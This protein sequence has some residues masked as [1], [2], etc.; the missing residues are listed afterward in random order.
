MY[1]P[2]NEIYEFGEFRLDVSERI[3]SRNGE[4][5]AVAEKAFETL[6]VLV[7]N[8]NHLL[9]KAE[10]MKAIWPDTIVEENNLDKNISYLRRILGEMPEHP[11]FIETV[12]G[13]GYRFAVNKVSGESQ[14]HPAGNPPAAR[15][16]AIAAEGDQPMS[17]GLPGIQSN[18]VSLAGWHQSE[19]SDRPVAAPNIPS[20]DEVVTRDTADAASILKPA[21]RR[22]IAILAG[23]AVI[24][25]AIG[26]GVY[27]RSR[28]PAPDVTSIAV[29][30]FFNTSH[31]PA[32][33]YLS[34]GITESIINDLSQTTGLKVMSR[35]SAFQFKDDQ[36]D[37]RVIAS[38]LGVQRIITGDITQVADKLVINVRLLDTV[39][40]SQIW[41]SQYVRTAADVVALQNEIASDISRKLGPQLPGDK[42]RFPIRYTDNPEAY[43]LFLKGRYHLE[44]HTPQ[45]ARKALRYFQDAAALDSNFAAAYAYIAYLYIGFA[46]AKDFPSRESN[47]KARENVM[48]SL[49]LDDQLSTA[50]EVYGFILLN[51]D[52]NFVAAEHEFLRALE[53]D[54]NDASARETYGLMLGSLGK[55][56]ESLTELQKAIDINPLSASISS[57]YGGAL[58]TARRYDEA[59]EHLKRSLEL[60]PDFIQTHYNLAIVYQM[61]G[62]YADSVEERARIAEAIRDPA[63]AGFIRES[64]AR[65]G[66]AGFLRDMTEDPHAPY[67]P[68]YIKATL[69]AA[70]GDKDKTLAILQKRYEEGGAGLTTLRVDPR[71]DPVRDDPRFAELLKR[72]NLE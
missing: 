70:R 63:A 67:V 20:G 62:N 23:V 25:S 28:D 1:Q 66:W 32:A 41:G 44:K 35:N 3:L 27:L 7:K 52:F 34:D 21:F 57:S 53:L 18:V 59:V 22:S 37:I 5:V 12:R 11:R 19:N 64:F 6:C 61:Q 30:P 16:A 24:V 2:N 60:D 15:A 50:H 33:E 69:Y 43:Q 4:R 71:F 10:L 65:G 48:R 36:H 38:K 31:D 13:R 8:G 29:L 46:G 68:P 58:V 17:N 40:S 14:I 26:V 56:D 51:F 49:R 42:K 72:I 54:P 45:D 55:H 9:T 47:L 39:D